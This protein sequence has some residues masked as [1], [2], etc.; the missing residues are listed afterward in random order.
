[1]KFFYKQSK[2]VRRKKNSKNL[3]KRTILIYKKFPKKNFFLKLENNWDK[4]NNALK[5]RKYKKI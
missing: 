5:K 1:M 3:K 2:N 4:E